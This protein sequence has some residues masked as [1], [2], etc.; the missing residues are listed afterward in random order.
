MRILF[1]DPPPKD[2]TKLYIG[3]CVMLVLLLVSITFYTTVA[4]YK[5]SKQLQYTHGKAID[6][7]EELSTVGA[8]PVAMEAVNKNDTI[9]IYFKH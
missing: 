5:L 8:T 4:W 9:F 1:P 3:I 7:P 6:L 2:Y